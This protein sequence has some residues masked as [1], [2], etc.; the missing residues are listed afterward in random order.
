MRGDSRPAHQ[1]QSV[2]EPA[3]APPVTQRP[4]GRVVAL[5]GGPEGLAVDAR[6]GDSRRR[7]PQADLGTRGTPVPR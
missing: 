1:G 4:A 5:A 7:D 3:T 6:D 2:P